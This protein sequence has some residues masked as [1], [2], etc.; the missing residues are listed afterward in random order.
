MVALKGPS[1]LRETGRE[2]HLLSQEE[3]QSKGIEKQK[4]NRQ[5]GMV[6]GGSRNWGCKCREMREK[7]KDRE[8]A[9]V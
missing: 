9:V 1:P 5:R 6:D 4:S 3:Q 8:K 2:N 7:G